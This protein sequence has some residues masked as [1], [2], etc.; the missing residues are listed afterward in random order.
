MTS[1]SCGT[2][3]H[4]SI[5]CWRITSPRHPANHIVLGRAEELSV[6]SPAP[7]VHLVSVNVAKP[8]VIGTQRGRPVL[9]A[10][11][12]RPVPP[13]ETLFLDWEN[14]AGDRQADLSVHGGPDK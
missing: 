11:K 9:S 10:I 14:L 4:W 12:K 1:Q 8:S 3:R 13:G 6:P 5:S 2:P 7:L